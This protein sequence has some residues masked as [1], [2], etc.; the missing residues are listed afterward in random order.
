MN[1]DQLLKLAD[2]EILWGTALFAFLIPLFFLPTTADFYDFNKKALLIVVASILMVTWLIRN[3]AAKNLRLTLTPTLLPLSILTLS[4]F[5]S[6]QVASVNKTQALLGRPVI[7]LSLLLLYIVITTRFNLKNQLRLVVNALTLSGATLGLIS[8]FQYTELTKQLFSS[9]PAWFTQSTFTPTGS[10]LSLLLTLSPLF[11][12]GLLSAIRKNQA[13]LQ[14]IYYSLA[15][16]LIAIGIGLTVAS[17]NDDNRIIVLPFNTSWE[18]AIENFK[19]ST[20]AIVGTGPESYPHAFTAGKPVSFNASDH[21]NLRFLS[22]R[23]EPF[24]LLTTHGL[25]GMAAYLW[26]IVMALKSMRPTLT[27]NTK[28][29]LEKAV[30][31]SLLIAI[32]LQLT[33]PVGTLS[34]TLLVLLLALQQS[35]RK[36]AGDEKVKDVILRLFAISVVKPGSVA[37]KKPEEILPWVLGA[38]ITIAI[39]VGLYFGAFN[40]YASESLFKKSLDAII[41]NR[42]TDT[43]NY[44]I[45]AIQKNPKEDRF[46]TSYALT[47]LALAN[48]IASKEEVSAQDRQNITQLL[49]QAIREAKE[50]TAL[51]PRNTTNW[52]TLANIYRNLINV[53]EGANQW[54]IASYVQAIQTNPNDPRLRLDLGGIY[55]GM[56]DFDQAIRFFEQAALLKNDWANAHFN[57]SAAYREKGEIQNAIEEMQLVLNF[58]DPAAADYAKAQEEFR[59][60]NQKLAKPIAENAPPAETE[61]SE[62]APLPSPAPPSEQIELEANSGPNIATGSATTV[63]TP[64]VSPSPTPQ[65]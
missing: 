6:L 24:H 38:P 58:L 26:L 51:N 1:K 36:A 39:L 17:L 40:V 52:E 53:T 54:A 21:W 41:Q 63:P 20:T 13:N 32:I 59:S 12:L 8:I 61:L 14:R 34:L 64:S 43:Y 3:I 15:T 4:S 23:N 48:S 27:G 5:I 18:V 49:Q 28:T 65:Q 46:H 2:K 25:I 31:A 10:P 57:L 44:Q 11:F 7:H 50:A 16:A 62:P 9:A 30:N 22:A 47:N 19:N 45:Q 33:Y 29:N 37:D 55:Y 56:G 42:G 35:L 60:L